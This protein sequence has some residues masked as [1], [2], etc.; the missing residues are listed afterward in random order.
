M[1]KKKRRIFRQVKW[2][3]KTL[4]NLSQTYLLIPNVMLF[5]LVQEIDSEIVVENYTVFHWCR[6]FPRSV[7]ANNFLRISSLGK[8]T[9]LEYSVNTPTMSNF[10][11]MMRC[12]PIYKIQEDLT[13]ALVNQ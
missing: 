4:S 12:Q 7:C 10:K 5:S 11:L 1:L 3:P 6:F 13:M 2:H 9:K 8:Q